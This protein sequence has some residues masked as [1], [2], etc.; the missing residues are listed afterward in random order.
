MVY[1]DH[2]TKSWS[3]NTVLMFGMC[4]PELVGVFQ[5]TKSYIRFCYIKEKIIKYDF[6]QSLLNCDM[7][8]CHWVNLLSQCI[9]IR[10]NAIK[11]VHWLV[12]SNKTYL[13]SILDD[14]NWSRTLF[15]ICSYKFIK[16]LIF[17]YK[18]DYVDLNNDDQQF[19]LDFLNQFFFNDSLLMCP[20]PVPIDVHPK[21]ACMFFIHILLTHGKYITKLDVLHLRVLIWLAEKEM[22]KLFMFTPPISYDCTSWMS[23]NTS[24]IHRGQDD[25]ILSAIQAKWPPKSRHQRNSRQIL[26][27]HATES[28]WACSNTLIKNSPIRGFV[29]TDSFM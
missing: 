12:E 2:K 29:Y 8:K 6:H 19:K 27:N 4:P 26:Q 20:V 22:T 5:Q 25:S 3:Y 23:S 24:L 21:F 1:H 28:H 13:N 9:Y 15:Y 17:I 7:R 18:T 16:D 14:T 10:I 11:E